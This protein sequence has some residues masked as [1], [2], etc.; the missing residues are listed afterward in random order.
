MSEFM[1]S[2][3][4]RT[5]AD[6]GATKFEMAVNATSN[7]I[8]TAEAN[9]P[10]PVPATKLAKADAS[11]AH[12]S[13]EKNKKYFRWTTASVVSG[14]TI[15]VF[16]ADFLLLEMN[17]ET[18]AS[19]LGIESIVQLLGF[20]I[21]SKMFALDCFIS[22]SL[23]AL[24]MYKLGYRGPLKGKAKPRPAKTRMHTAN[25]R[26]RENAGHATG[27][28]TGNDGTSTRAAPAGPGPVSQWNQAIDFAARQGD[29]K[30]AGNLL[31][32]FERQGNSQH[33]HRPDT[34]SYNLVIRACAKKGDYLAAEG[35]LQ[36]M[37]SN[38]LEATVCSYNTVLDAC[39]KADNAESC[40]SW[41]KTMLNRGV[42]AN[43][44][45]YATAIYARARRGDEALAEQWLQR[46]I[47]AGVAPDAVCY[48]SMIHACGVSGNAA[49]AERWIEEM[50]ARGLAATVTTFTAVIDACAKA[51]DVPRAEKWLEAMIAAGVEPNVVTF[52]AMID[53]CAK[54]S[55]PTRAEHWHNRMLQCN[56][57]PNAHSYSAVINA[58]AKAGDVAMAEHWLTL[59]EEAGVANDVVLYS[60]VIDACGKVGDADRAMLVFQRMQ[61][62][63]IRPHIVAYAALA[64]PFAYK[65]DWMAVEKIANEMEASGI[66]PNEYFLYAQL[67]SYAT[68][69]PR[70]SERA[71]QCFRKS[72]RCGI[73]PNDHVVSALARSLGRDRC[74]ELMAE[75]C[76]GRPVPFPP[77]ARQGKGSG[78]GKA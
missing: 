21:S 52:S 46:M 26:R 63:G 5:P 57:K 78:K 50:Q 61:E 41:L 4:V 77:A 2:I 30:K 40:E 67:L 27:N 42:E 6:A 8:K 10:A 1:V 39:A 76:Q 64:R 58:C 17:A 24:I 22:V 25:Q 11:F 47:E 71:E 44:I 15:T 53:A 48:N 34:V 70:Q 73:K 49:G 23:L 56:V 18:R 75:L 62:N 29:A 68:T 54:A 31:L 12:V 7:A 38:G 32:E 36:R 66:I 69:R 13:S 43:V 59:S 28:D 72:L 20:A 9:L 19:W 60:S 14:L 35:W 37:E 45:S 33:G 51:V 55:S 3:C 16:L 65:G 74:T